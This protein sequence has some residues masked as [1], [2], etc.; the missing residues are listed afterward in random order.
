MTFYMVD[1]EADGPAPS[2]YS[3]IS[4]GAVVVDTSLS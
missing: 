3:M 1:I 4:L 2:L